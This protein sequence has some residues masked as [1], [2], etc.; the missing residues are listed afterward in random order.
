ME[1][2]QKSGY[3]WI[4]FITILFAYLLIV[5]QRTAP[6]LIT[7][8]LMDEFHIS[9]STLGVL[10]GIQFV[11]YAGFQVPFGVLADRFGP[12]RF[13]IIG[14]LLDGIGTIFYSTASHEAVLMI[15]RL[16]VGTGDAMIWINLVLILS[17]WFS[18][19]EFAALLGWAGMS[20]SLGSILATLPFTYWI[21]AAG[22][23][24]PFL[25]LGLA[26]C[27]WAFLLYFVLVKRPKQLKLT[28]PYASKPSTKQKESVRS[29]LRRVFRSRQAW[30]TFFCHFGL[31][32]TYVG[33]IGSWAIPY[34]MNVYHMTRSHASEFIMLGLLGSVIGGPI[35]GWIS[36]RFQMRKLP[37]IIVHLLALFSWTTFLWMGGKPPLAM[38]TILYVLIGYANG[39]SMLTFA[40][41]RHSFSET[42]VG[43][44]TGFANMGGFLS[45]VLLPALFGGVLDHF[46]SSSAGTGYSYGFIIP[47][48]FS[49]IGFIGGL[50]IVEKRE[51]SKKTLQPSA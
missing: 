39:A 18:K 3:K 11:S 44:V 27:A 34:G 2:E 28:P 12:A 7:D 49:F 47:V 1:T 10:A 41:V 51:H 17:H 33:F 50:S 45:A 24:M 32:G 21:A 48:L 5:S 42:E 4:V 23:R 29:I 35:T 9:A 25:T 15:A 19:R 16:L 8:R 26:L 36:T 6:G 37:Y 31:V 14:T 13:L 38:L 40:V 22:W 43:V 20:G 30:A 46:A